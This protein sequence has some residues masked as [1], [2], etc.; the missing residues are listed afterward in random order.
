MNTY[1]SLK[2]DLQMFNFA[3]LSTRP[4]TMERSLVTLERGSVGEVTEGDN[5]YTL[6]STCTIHYSN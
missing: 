3:P 1:Y 5:H 4:L 6:H 2:D